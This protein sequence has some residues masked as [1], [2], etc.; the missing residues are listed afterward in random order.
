M[1]STKPSFLAQIFFYDDK[2]GSTEVVSNQFGSKPA[3]VPCRYILT[4]ALAL[5]GIDD[6]FPAVRE[7]SDLAQLRQ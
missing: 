5:Q 6:A 4:L 2:E 3:V 1:G 7:Q